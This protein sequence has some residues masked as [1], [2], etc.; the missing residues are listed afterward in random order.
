[1]SRPLSQQ[2]LSTVVLEELESSDAESLRVL[3]VRMS[4]MGDVI[5][6]LP[7]IAALRA[8]RPNW[9]VGWLIEQRWMELLC[10]H[11]A[12]RLQPRSDTEAAGRLGARFRFQGMA[13]GP[14]VC[15]DM[16]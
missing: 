3:V 8:A 2:D 12:E 10:A 1:M 9:Q 5:H 13:Q 16:A 15:R 14:V 4:A 11:A 6:G 7:A